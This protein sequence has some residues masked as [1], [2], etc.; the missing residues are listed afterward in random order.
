MLSKYART[1]RADGRQLSHRPGLQKQRRQVV[2]FGLGK[3]TQQITHNVK[4]DG[5]SFLK[6][7]QL[8]LKLIS[9]GRL[10][11]CRPR[12]SE[13]ALSHEDLTAVTRLLMRSFLHFTLSAV[14]FHV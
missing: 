2:I 7:L 1:S 8:L 12:L 14:L 10:F 11:W 4:D 5:M 9:C 13:A 3:A 6:R